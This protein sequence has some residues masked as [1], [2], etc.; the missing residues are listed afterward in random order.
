MPNIPKRRSDGTLNFPDYPSF[1]PNLTPAEVLQQGAFGGTYF[2]E[3]ESNPCRKG[4]DAAGC[5]NGSGSKKKTL[6]NQHKEFPKHWFKGLDIPKYV[7]SST[8]DKSIN[9]Y[10]V[11]SGTSLDYWERKGWINP[12]DPYGWF[13]WYC[14]F[15]QGRR[16]PDD[17]RQID[18]WM[19]VASK[20]SGRFRKRLANMIEAANAKDGKNHKNDIQI[21]PVIRQLLHQWAVT[22]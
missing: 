3:I 14:R 16:T 5:E 12:Q 2:R 17:A 20:D 18:R 4:N 6:K 1:R 13:Q 10:G 19:G 9:K 21:S 7:T 22:I 11:I 8:C 15:Y